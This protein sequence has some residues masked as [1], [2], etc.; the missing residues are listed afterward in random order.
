MKIDVMVDMRP[1]LTTPP[2]V[3][4][5]LRILFTGVDERGI[6]YLLYELRKKG[7]HLW[8]REDEQVWRKGGK[9]RGVTVECSKTSLSESRSRDLDFW[10]SEIQSTG[11]NRVDNVHWLQPLAYYYGATV[12]SVESAGLVLLRCIRLTSLLI[13]K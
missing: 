12:E 11:I 7:T 6:I 2:R 4:F 10:A 5:Q 9:C 13:N 3:Q 1:I 8:S